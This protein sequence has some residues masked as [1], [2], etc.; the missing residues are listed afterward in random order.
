MKFLIVVLC[1]CAADLAIGHD[2]VINA[3]VVA[4]ECIDL[5]QRRHDLADCCDYPRIHF[6]KIFASH[7]IDEC[8]GTKDTCCAMLCVWRNTKVTFH[9]G[10]VNLTGLKR[11]LLESVRHKDEWANLISKAVDQCDAEG[12]MSNFGSA[13]YLT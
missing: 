4:D 12:F 2:L 7:C 10:G 11:T 6:F 5:N 3:T 13:T 1:L 8:A 9:D